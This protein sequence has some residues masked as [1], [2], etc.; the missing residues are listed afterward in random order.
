MRAT[1]TR[2]IRSL[3]RRLNYL[4]IHREASRDPI[5]L[6]AMGR[7][8]TTSL[9]EAM[10]QATDRPVH[11]LHRMSKAGIHRLRTELRPDGAP[12]LLRHLVGHYWRRRLRFDRTRRDVVTAMREPIAHTISRFFQVA[13]LLGLIEREP[14][15]SQPLQPLVDAM[16][17]LAR[18]AGD[19]DFFADELAPSLG[20]DVYARPFQAPSTTFETE[21]FRL[22]VYR[23]EDLET[24][25][26]QALP[27]FLGLQ[28]PLQLRRIHGS[29]QLPYAQLYERFCDEA[30][31]PEWMLDAAYQRR[32]ARHFYSEAER[33]AFRKRWTRR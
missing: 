23:F 7:T 20:I 8:G 31:L 6:F 10:A 1:H 13:P 9:G 30:V 33:D 29:Q 14:D 28:A 17:R 21:R 25:T 4:R 11:K 32:D 15:P 19:F 24:V 16:E 5:L 27:A 26:E 2:G 22:L 12:I 18:E 3:R